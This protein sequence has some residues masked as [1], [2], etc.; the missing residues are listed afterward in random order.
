MNKTIFLERF[1]LLVS[2]VQGVEMTPSELMEIMEEEFLGYGRA[3]SEDFILDTIFKLWTLCDRED[4][5]DNLD[6]IFDSMVV[7]VN[8][9]NVGDKIKPVLVTYTTL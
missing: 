3:F 2:R 8:C 4:L 1:E 9:I 5:D 7:T 6:P